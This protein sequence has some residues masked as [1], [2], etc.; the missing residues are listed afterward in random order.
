MNRSEIKYL[1]T[2][3]TSKNPRNSAYALWKAFFSLVVFLIQYFGAKNGGHELETIISFFRF[4]YFIGLGLFGLYHVEW[5][6]WQKVW[7]KP[8]QLFSATIVGLCTSAFLIILIIFENYD[9]F[10]C[11]GLSLGFYHFTPRTVYVRT[12][13]VYVRTDWSDWNQNVSDKPNGSSREAGRY[14]DCELA[15]RHGIAAVFVRDLS[16]EITAEPGFQI[17]V[18]ESHSHW[19]D[20]HWINIHLKIYLS[21]VVLHVVINRPIKVWD[22][23]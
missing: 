18:I 4:H 3:K 16:N 13:T 14:D 10:F 11:T 7:N 5:I 15:P 19:L 20:G 17:D 22:S 1:S 9:H 23:L 6:F 8:L 21:P 12:K 2:E